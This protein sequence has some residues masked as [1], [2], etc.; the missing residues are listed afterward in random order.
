M[1]AQRVV[2][3]P[4]AAALL[5]VACGGGSSPSGPAPLATH[6][7]SVVVYYDQNGNGVRDASEV[8]RLGGVTVSA[9]GA[10]GTSARLTG[11]ATLAG[12]PAGMQT[13]RARSESLPPYFQPRDVVA[14]VP[15]SGDLEL[16]VVLPI[17]AN[18][19]AVYLALGDSITVGDG[20]SNGLGYV[21][22][23]EDRLRVEW[24]QG[25]V[26]NDGIEGNKSNQ[27]A[28]R[29]GGDLDRFRPACVLIMLGTN[30]WN[31]CKDVDSCYTQDAVRSMLDQAFAAQTQPFLA[32]II[33]ANPDDPVRNPPQRNEWVEAMN[34][35]LKMIASEKG[36][37]VVDLHGAF[38]RASGAELGQLFAD[39]VHP[40]D[41]GHEIIA[42]EFFR[43]LTSPR[44]AT[45][46]ASAV[47][48]ARLLRNPSGGLEL[49]LPDD[50]AAS[51]LAA[52]RG[53]R[54]LAVTPPLSSSPAT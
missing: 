40:N 22:L 52:P 50:D 38:M 7:V 25:D 53:L 2:V 41:R 30:D 31:K 51:P 16:P 10:N 34:E 29:I 35:R 33:P 17:G 21:P 47:D 48:P 36:A 18:V 12:V 9:G 20:S 26:V 5:E 54:P 15:V 28:E 3:V 46:S 32:T 14:G 6:T 8:T 13:F 23:L 19:P 4:L 49:G 39:H 27:G 11:R 45:A 1:R 44:S 24:A 42:D 37:V 43:V